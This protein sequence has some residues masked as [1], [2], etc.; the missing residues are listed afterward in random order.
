MYACAFLYF[1]FFFQ[2]ISFY[3]ARI[4]YLIIVSAIYKSV[5]CIQYNLQSDNFIRFKLHVY[6]N[7]KQI[8]NKRVHAIIQTTR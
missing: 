1:F 4:V 3:I 7:S 8:L 2:K 6:S 5:H